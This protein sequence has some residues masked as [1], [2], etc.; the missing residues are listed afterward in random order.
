MT[1]RT[2]TQLQQTIRV[3]ILFHKDVHE[4]MY[5]DL[6]S[7]KLWEKLFVFYFGSKPV[8]SQLL[9]THHRSGSDDPR[10]SVLL[11]DRKAL[12]AQRIVLKFL[13]REQVR[14]QKAA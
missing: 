8:S 7:V 4:N 12:R 3:L 2:Y 11:H 1:P 5:K 9:P 6:Y 13:Q 14:N 10:W